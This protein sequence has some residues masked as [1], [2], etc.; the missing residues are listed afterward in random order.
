MVEV[1][2]L[3]VV[4]VLVE[5]PGV[6]VGHGLEVGVE[7]V[8]V[9]PVGMAALVVVVLAVVSCVVVLAGQVAVVVLVVSRVAETIAAG[10]DEAQPDA[11]DDVEAGRELDLVEE[12]LF[13]QHLEVAGEGEQTVGASLMLRTN[14]VALHITKNTPIS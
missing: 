9:V 11:E 2:L 13:F 3:L 14:P 12:L 8:H 7:L 1:G 6:V 5:W 10:L 4:Q